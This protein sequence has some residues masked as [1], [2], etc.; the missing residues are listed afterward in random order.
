MSKDKAIKK[1]DQAQDTF[2]EI[3]NALAT[4]LKQRNSLIG[5]FLAQ[6]SDKTQEEHELFEELMID[7][8]YRKKHD[9]DSFFDGVDA[10][11]SS[12]ELESRAE[13][14]A[15]GYDLDNLTAAQALELCEIRNS[16]YKHVKIVSNPTHEKT[17][18][19]LKNKISMIQILK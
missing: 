15:I 2:M 6:L 12:T 1:F 16:F 18:A 19:N 8:S 9:K 3:S 4:A 13:L 10:I 17:I 5:Y 11:E 7:E 14:K